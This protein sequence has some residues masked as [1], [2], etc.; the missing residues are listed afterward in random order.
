MG[1]VTNLRRF[2]LPLF[3]FF[4]AFIFGYLVKTGVDFLSP[5]LPQAEQVS[6]AVESYIEW[7]YSQRF[8]TVQE[9]FILDPLWGIF[10]LNTIT[11]SMNIWLGP[12]CVWIIT[13]FKESPTPPS[14][15]K[16]TKSMNKFL[17]VRTKKSPSQL[18]FLYLAPLT[19]VFWLGFDGGLFTNLVIF[20]HPHAWVEFFTAFYAA[21]IGLSLSEISLKRAGKHFLLLTPIIFLAAILELPLL[22]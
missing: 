1:K 22:V 5:L 4:F 15:K 16:F 21:S 19:L 3:I 6:Q 20:T 13:L 17:E 12:L 2:L 18:L 9:T 10:L 11:Y 14:I 8:E 7:K